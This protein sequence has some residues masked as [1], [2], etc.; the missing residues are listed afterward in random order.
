MTPSQMAT[1]ATLTRE[2]PLSPG[3]LAHAE[4]VQPPSMTRILNSLQ[5]AGMVTRTAHP[6]DGRQ[7]LYET[8]DAARTVLRKDR[9]RRDH[10][11]ARKMTTLSPQDRQT[12]LQAVPI[13]NA[14][15]LD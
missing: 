5:E 10:W 11:L 15:A 8:T 1:L 12:L 14:I 4:R 3:D 9:E 13:L 6:T 2:G 7:V